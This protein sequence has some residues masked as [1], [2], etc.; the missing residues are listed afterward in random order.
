MKPALLSELGIIFLI[1]NFCGISSLQ[2]CLPVLLYAVQGQNFTVIFLKLKFTKI[3]S[4]K[5]IL[6][7]YVLDHRRNQ[8]SESEWVKTK[9]VQS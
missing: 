7:G 5:S 8:E 1:I 2:I 3:K 6:K 4:F 9:R